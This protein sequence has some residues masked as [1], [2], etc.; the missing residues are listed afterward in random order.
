MD[1]RTVYC[2]VPCIDVNKVY[3]KDEDSDTL[4]HIAILILAEDLAFY[5]IDRTPWFTSLNIQNKLL[6]TP[7]HL[8]VL[9]NH[10]SLVRRLVVAGA[11]RES[12]DKEGNMAIH[13][14]CR[15]NLVTILRSLL[16]PISVEEQKRNNYDA[17]VQKI[18]QNLDS[19]NYEGYTCLH[20]GSS[21]DH[22]DIVKTLIENN[23]NI[24]VKAEK[25]GR[26]ILHE[27][28]WSGKIKMAKYLISLGKRCEISAKTYD[29]YTAFD[30][31]RSR[32][33]W[34]IVIELATAGAKHGNEEME[35]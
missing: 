19:K 31:A 7:L 6:Q 30:L 22:M 12:R 23:A 35:Q 25:S 18:P 13:L 17:P 15:D 33:H 9:T 29:G 3:R 34:S 20:I 16:E 2:R 28:A 5:F 26:T 24:N 32:G 8:A 14:A 4:L 11:D 10:V 1:A 21:F 27:A